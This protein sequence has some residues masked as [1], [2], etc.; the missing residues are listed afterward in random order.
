MKVP[1][2]VPTVP[3]PTPSVP[4]LPVPSTH[5]QAPTARTP[6]LPGPSVRVPAPSTPSAG[7]RSTQSGTL[8][9]TTA[10]ITGGGSSADAPEASSAYAAAASDRAG[11]AGKHGPTKLPAGD[12]LTTPQLRQLVRALKGCLS[13]LSTRQT[14]L[15][16]LRAGIG[17]RQSLTPH[18]V[19]R[20]LHV[21]VQRESRIER[22]AVT[23]LDRAS[24]NGRCPNPAMSIQTAVGRTAG[25]ILTDLAQPALIAPPVASTGGRRPG[26][27]SRNRSGSTPPS[28]NGSKSSTTSQVR[29]ASVAPS[30]QGGSDLLL[31]A[32]AVAAGLGVLWLI[33]ARLRAAEPEHGAVRQAPRALPRGREDKAMAGAVGLAALRAAP[34]A[35]RAPAERPPIGSAN[36]PSTV[37]GDAGAPSGALTDAV[38]ALELGGALVERGDLA[39]AEAAYRRADEQ[40]HPS[41]ASSLGVVLEQRGDAAGAEAAYRRA[42]RRGDATGAFNLG[43]MLAERND[44]ESAEAAFRRADE[45]GDPLAASNLGMMLEQRRDLAG[46]EAAYRRADQRG[47]ATGAF[48]LGAL[49]EDRDD[50]AGAE[51]AYRR[52]CE[53]GRGYVG[54]LAR[55]ALSLLRARR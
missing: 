45:R 18:Q 35:E 26:T 10:P 42:D 49:L 25:S 15:L 33:L 3:V 36:T 48:K 53:R 11:G 22:Q 46:A 19:A 38:A 37:A 2:V 34:P 21:S 8:G 16:T 31:L 41:A 55:A 28:K 13:A 32:L 23:A 27:T 39:G 14:K 17:R 1:P 47:D 44:L 54:D 43:A 4:R 20:V 7:A 5:A 40:G 29:S 52:A 9:S 24:A 30:G 6:S 51:A 50:L 12:K